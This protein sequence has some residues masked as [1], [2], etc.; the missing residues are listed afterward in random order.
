MAHIN[1]PV[2]IR[3][4]ANRRLYPTGAG[5]DVTLESLA[6]LV[7]DDDGFVAFDAE[8]GPYTTRSVLHATI[9]ERTCHG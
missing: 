6:E 8:S 9:I 5:S 3:R 4:Y 7:E 2:A 1:E